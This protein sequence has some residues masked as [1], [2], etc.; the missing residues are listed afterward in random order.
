MFYCRDAISTQLPNIFFQAVYKFSQGKLCFS[1]YLLN[2][3]NSGC[4]M[5]SKHLQMIKSNIDTGSLSKHKCRSGRLHLVVCQSGLN[6]SEPGRVTLFKFF[7]SLR[8]AKIR[9][10]EVWK[11]QNERGRNANQGKAMEKKFAVRNEK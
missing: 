9:L 5:P 6:F 11:R 3:A 1:K 8:S 7:I 2:F 4:W 10:Q